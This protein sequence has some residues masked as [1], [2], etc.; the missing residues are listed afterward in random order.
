MN[1]D[2]GVIKL[3]DDAAKPESNLRIHAIRFDHTFNYYSPYNSTDQLGLRAYSGI[4]TQ[5]TSKYITQFYFNLEGM[6][7]DELKTT[8]DK[9]DFVKNCLMIRRK[10]Q[11]MKNLDWRDHKEFLSY[12]NETQTAEDYKNKKFK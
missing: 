9:S 2:E 4:V 3:I 8:K 7:F 12:W 11:Q 5:F 1:I 6:L 10:E